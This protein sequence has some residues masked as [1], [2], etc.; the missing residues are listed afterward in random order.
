MKPLLSS[1]FQWN[2][3]FEKS[4]QNIKNSFTVSVIL[5]YPNVSK[6]FILDTDASAL[7]LGAVLSQIGPDGNE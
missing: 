6:T 3:E 4:Y 2:E 5:C 1:T 7:G